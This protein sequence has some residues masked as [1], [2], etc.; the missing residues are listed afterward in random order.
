MGFAHRRTSH[1]LLPAVPALGSR[2]ERAAPGG[3]G[4]PRRWALLL[5]LHRDLAAGG[6]LPD[7][8]FDHRGDD[9]V[10]YERHRR[11]GVVRLP[12][13]ADGVDRPLYRDRTLDRRR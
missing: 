5:F 6:L 10:P 11:P 3:A 1:L 2:P 8:A 13:S 4:R 7:R 9:A 12:L